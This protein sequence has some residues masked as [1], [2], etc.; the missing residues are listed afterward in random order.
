VSFSPVGLLYP[1]VENNPD[2]GVLVGVSSG[3]RYRMPTGDILWRVDDKPFRTLRAQDNPALPS[4]LAVANTDVAS[5]AMQDAVA[6]TMRLTIAATASS[7][8]AS[9]ES[10]GDTR[11]DAPWSGAPFSRCI[12]SARLRF[13]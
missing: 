13:T 12:G 7:T 4:T 9:G 11:R 2:Q 3:G 10:K 8:V 6:L 5:K 1:F